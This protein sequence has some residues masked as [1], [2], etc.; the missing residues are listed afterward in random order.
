V[1]VPD[2]AKKE[3]EFIFVTHM[4]DVLKAALE[5]PPF[6]TPAG[7]SSGGEQPQAPLPG[8][9]ADG[10]APEIRAGETRN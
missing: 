2:Q 8:A 1:D 6:K 9:A 3:L 4:D 7:S 10:S 5:T